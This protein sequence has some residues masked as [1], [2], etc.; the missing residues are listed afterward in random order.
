[1]Q[2]RAFGPLTTI[3][4]AR[5]E[6]KHRDYVNFAQSAKNFKNILKTLAVKN[7]KKL[8]S[9]MR[10]GLFTMPAFVFPG[11]CSHPDVQQ[12]SMYSALIVTSDILSDQVII[13]GTKYKI[14]NVLITKVFSCDVLQVGTVIKVVMRKSSVFFLVLLSDAA[15]NKL[16]FFETL[17]TDSVTLIEYQQ[18][19]DFKP[20]FKRGNNKCFPFVL[21]HHLCTTF[22]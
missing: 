3:W 19:A 9:R 1:M 16:G 6:S 20:I 4:T 2:M 8:A 18:L 14:G 7:Q 13:R 11:K 12:L 15:R 22:V 17:P 21:H 5:F 10:N